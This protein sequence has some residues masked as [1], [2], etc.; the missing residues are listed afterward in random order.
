V[1]RPVGC[2]L[3]VVWSGVHACF[4]C[5]LVGGVSVSGTGGGLVPWVCATGRLT[6]AQLWGIY[7]MPAEKK[8]VVSK[9]AE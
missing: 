9:L 5:V 2:G 8:T 7:P 6:P 4:G 3:G 1:L